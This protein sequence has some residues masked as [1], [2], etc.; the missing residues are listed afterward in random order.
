LATQAGLTVARAEPEHLPAILELWKELMD[1]HAPF[2]PLFT[3][4][5]D[6]EQTFASHL[7]DL[8]ASP[9]ALVVVALDGGDVVGYAMASI[10]SYPPVFVRKRYGS[11]SDMAV[12]AGRRR[13]GS[14]ERMLDH[15]IAWFRERR[16]DRIEVRVAAANAVG[17]AFWSKH[18]F[19]PYMQT[20]S[21]EV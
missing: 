14:G 4:A 19:A 21:R 5:D 8:I 3:R 18:G 16:L 17:A 15:L 1:Y 12:R 2:D 6:G 13:R 20:M 10:G 11:I 7:R 9:D